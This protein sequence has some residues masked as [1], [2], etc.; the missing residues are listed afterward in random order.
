[1]LLDVYLHK[2][3]GKVNIPHL[4]G[5]KRTFPLIMNHVTLGQRGGGCDGSATR[6][7]LTINHQKGGK[8]GTKVD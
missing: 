7:L 4:S 5:G 1:M 8:K 6:E 3:D 2:R